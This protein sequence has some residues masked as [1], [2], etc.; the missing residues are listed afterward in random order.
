M[1]QS[2]GPILRTESLK[3]VY[4]RRAVVE[5]VSI[6]LA[7]G[8][9]VGLLGPNGAGKTTTFG[10]V[11]RAGM[12]DRETVSLLGIDID[13]RFTIVFGLAA[14]VVLDLPWELALLTGTILAS[15]DAVLLRDVVRDPRL[16]LSIRH[17]LSVEAGTNDLIVLPLTQ[18][19]CG[20]MQCALCL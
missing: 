9:V 14:V 12:A 7:C 4:Q 2:N 19:G 8:E 13:R 11:V 6:E 16:P 15:T 17:T 3:K 10:M 1:S 18:R 20:Q 5:N